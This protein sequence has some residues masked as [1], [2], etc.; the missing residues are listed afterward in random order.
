M[1]DLYE[2]CRYGAIAILAFMVAWRHP[3]HDQHCPTASYVNGVHPV[4]EHVGVYQCL[5]TPALRHEEETGP[6]YY[7]QPPLPGED[8]PVEEGMIVCTGGQIPILKN[9]RTVGCQA[10]H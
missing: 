3:Q 9:E 10:R 4:A 8:D 7:V 1:F 2:F 6:H 5:P